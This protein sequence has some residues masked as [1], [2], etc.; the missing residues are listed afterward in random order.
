MQKD[1]TSLTDEQWAVIQQLMDWTPPP[2][3]GVRRSNL[4]KVWNS[5]LYIL[6]RGCRWADL[7]PDRNVYVAR[8][9]AHQ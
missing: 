3:R 8:A 1:F 4:R 7:P 5:I 6:L 9:T 2:E